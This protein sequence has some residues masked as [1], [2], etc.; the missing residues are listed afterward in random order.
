VS[1]VDEAVTFV[2]QLIFDPEQIYPD[3]NYQL[4]ES[5][6]KLSPPP[7][8]ARRLRLLGRGLLDESITFPGSDDARALAP[9]LI[10]RFGDN[11]SIRA[12]FTRLGRDAD[13]LPQAVTRA[14]CAVVAGCGKEG[15][16]A[17]QATASTL[18]RNHLSEFF[19]LLL[20]VRL[21]KFVPGRFKHRMRIAKDSIS[22][23]SFVDMRSIL[24]ARILGLCTHKP[25][26]QWLAAAKVTYVEADISPFELR[27]VERLWPTSDHGK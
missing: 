17:V 15:F 1:T 7:Q 21:F 13:S 12:L 14:I 24:A 19:K 4:I 9:L 20:R 11:R 23:A 8:T 10:L 27:L 5:L 2:E 18:L 16:K 25:V 26:H 22:G 6:L 3:V